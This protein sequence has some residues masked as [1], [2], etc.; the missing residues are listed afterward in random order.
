MEESIKEI[1]SISD[2]ITLGKVFSSQ[3]VNNSEYSTFFRG[4]N[5]IIRNNKERTESTANLF[6]EELTHYNHEAKYIDNIISGICSKNFDTDKGYMAKVAKIQ[7]YGGK[8]RLLDFTEDY[9]IALF[10]ACYSCNQ[11]NSEEDSDGL[12]YHFKT[13]CLDFTVIDSY[14]KKSILEDYIKYDGNSI[15]DYY[16]WIKAEEEKYK[17]SIEEIRS[18]ISQHHFIKIAPSSIRMKNQKGLFL[19]MG[20]T[21]L[22]NTAFSPDGIKSKPNGITIHYGRGTYYSGFVGHVKVKSSAKKDLLDYLKKACEIDNNFIFAKDEN[23]KGLE[24]FIKS[25]KI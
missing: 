6:R 4:E 20:E 12:I 24:N 10:F 11:N 8:T 3:I 1:Y 2:A 16:K 23:D 25:I 9:W 7:H 22:N 19:Y 17:I 5:C 15:Q 21:K 18:L 13:D 14:Y